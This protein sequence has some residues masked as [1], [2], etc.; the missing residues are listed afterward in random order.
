MVF[1][2][3][4]SS[5]AR[6]PTLVA[7]ASR[8]D[9][10]L[11]IV[12]MNEWYQGPGSELLDADSKISM[13]RSTDRC[14]AALRAWFDWH[15]LQPDDDKRSLRLSDTNAEEQARAILKSVDGSGLALSESTS[16]KILASYGIPLPAEELARDPDQAAA[17]AERLGGAVAVKIVSS[18]IPHKSDIGGVRLG[19]S[20]A[21]EVRIAAV[22]IFAAAVRHAPDASID[23]VSVQQMASPG[24]EIVLGV[25]NDPQFGPLIAVGI[26]GVLVEL[27]RDNAVRLAPVSENK[28]HAMVRSLKGY[29]LLCGFRGR[30]AV[31]VD[32]LV[33]T[34]CRVSE[35][36]HDLSDVI[37][38]IDVNP[39]IVGDEGVMAADALVVRRAPKC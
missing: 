20:T 5:G 3:S 7:A 24:V 6:A 8:T 19:L 17:A 1:A 35:L 12:W 27:L 37:D 29:P 15:A 28:A 25:K 11:A 34:I 21:E 26:G 9:R 39:V 18:D 36:A 31:D 14:F 2:H 33:D 23:G 30:S 22:E 32:A 4:A 10:P 16:K 13:F 38:E